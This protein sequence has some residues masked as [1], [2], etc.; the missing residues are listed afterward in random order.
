MAVLLLLTP[1][2]GGV[3]H[4][5]TAY[6]PLSV[7]NATGG[8][9]FL[10]AFLTFGLSSIMVG[11]NFIAT[12]ITLRAP[13]MT[14]GRLPIFVWGIFSAALL[15]LTATQFVAY[16]LLMVILDRVVGMAFF[17]AAR[18]ET[19]CCTSTSSGSIP[20]PPCTS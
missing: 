18:G 6:P 9:L 8:L 5:W 16:G 17:D 15:S 11:M 19:R 20:T 10:L 12:I 14:W 7:I 1:F 2:F 13:G 3:D 4:G